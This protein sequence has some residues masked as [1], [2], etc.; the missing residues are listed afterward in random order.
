MKIKPFGDK[1][2]L[3]QFED[4]I[5]PDIHSLVIHFLQVLKNKNIA[6]VQYYVPAFASIT[7]GF[8]PQLWHFDDLA[9]RISRFWSK[10]YSTPN[11]EKEGAMLRIPVCFDDQYALDRAE[12]C[13]EIDMGWSDVIDLFTST[14]YTVYMIGFL[15]GFPYL[16]LLPPKLACARKGVPRKKVPAQSVGLAGR[17]AGIY[18]S[19]SPGGWQIIGSTPVKPFDPMRSEYFLFESGVKVTFQQISTSSYKDITRQLEDSPD[20]VEAFYV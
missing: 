8:D 12:L 17:Q 9:E 16:G 19:N 20:G 2:I 3:L 1:A 11:V 15:P 18:P 5:H 14:T 4:R 10:I 13:A 6:G 7:I